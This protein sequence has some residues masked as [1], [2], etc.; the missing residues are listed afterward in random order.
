[1]ALATSRIKSIILSPDACLLEAD[2]LIDSDDH[3]IYFRS[4]DILLTGNVEAFLAATLLPAMKAGGTL[5]AKGKVSRRFLESLDTIV[6]IFCCWFPAL[7]RVEVKG[8]QSSSAETSREGRVGVFFSGGVDSFYTFLKHRD[9]ITDLIYVHGFDM[10]LEN[11]PLRQRISSTLHEIGSSFGKRVIEVETN[12]RSF[13]DAYFRLR[14]MWGTLTHVVVLASVGHVLFPFFRKIFIAA[15]H[16]YCDLFPW[17]SHPLLD[18]LW[19]TESLEFIHDGCEAR[20]IDKVAFL[21]NFDIALKSLQVCRSPHSQG[22]YNCGIC[23]KCLTT[24][25]NL[26][27]A[28]TLDRCTAFNK[29]LDSRRVGKLVVFDTSA[30]VFSRENLRALEKNKNDQKLY[31]ALCR[32][33]NRPRWQALFITWLR[34]KGRQLKR[35]ADGH[36]H[37][38][39]GCLSKYHEP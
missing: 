14:E 9:E 26:H 32:V 35:F 3:H 33:L 30:L 8:V 36:L 27:L 25:I 12:V 18:P 21:S 28:G 10:S 16:T 7:H 15:T 5:S 2:I 24:M 38:N 23:E 34:H 31:R 11:H 19:S 13:L 37:K 20:R 29:R 39:Q 17:G 4:N 22:A 6:D 1:M